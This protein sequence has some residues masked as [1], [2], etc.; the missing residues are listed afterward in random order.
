MFHLQGLKTDILMQHL[1]T[2]DG[3]VGREI[4]I[5]KQFFGRFLYFDMILSLASKYNMSIHVF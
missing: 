2:H 3:V 5:C 1:Q 4:E